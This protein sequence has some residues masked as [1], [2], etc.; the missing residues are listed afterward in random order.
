MSPAER[1]RR[2]LA[3]VR[4]QVRRR[5]AVVDEGVLRVLGTLVTLEA[6]LKQTLEAQPSSF[7]AFRLP[8]VI[9]ELEGHIE[10]WRLRAVGEAERAMEL[11]WTVGPAMVEAPLLAAE[12]RIGVTLIPESLLTEASRF[13]ADKI[14]GLGPRALGRIDEQ[15]R[16]AVLGGQSPHEA[17]RAVAADLGEG[18]LRFVGFRSE[19][20][21][22]TEMGRLHSMAG[23][24]RLQDAARQVAGLKKQWIWSGKSRQTHADERVNGQV[25]EVDE[26]YDVAGEK[27]WYPRDPAGSAE[28]TINCGC[29]SVPYKE[30]WK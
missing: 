8:E 17:M 6:Q 12:I 26:Q 1:R 7:D 15:I 24:R 30:D 3:A 27:L 19:T 22:R 29:E 13:T 28:N 23:D 14:Q 21:V 2:F 20:V 9:R 18:H 5:G 16:R 11:A 4:A 25:R 10:R